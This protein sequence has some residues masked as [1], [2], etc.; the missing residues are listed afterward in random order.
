[1]MG[2]NVTI[3]GSDNPLAAFTVSGNTT[4]FADKSDGG[5]VYTAPLTA[6]ATATLIARKQMGVTSIAGDASGVYW[7][8]GDCRIMSLALGN[9][10]GT[11]KWR[12]LTSATRSYKRG[13]TSAEIQDK[14]EGQ[15]TLVGW[16]LARFVPQH[17]HRTRPAA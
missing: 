10:V 12:E 9:G 4:Y 16:A 17:G 11:L 1:M 3:T 7:A 15:S 8:A 6:N 2:S 14:T 13:A 5:F